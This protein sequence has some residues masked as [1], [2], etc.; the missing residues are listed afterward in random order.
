MLQNG[1]SIDGSK[2]NLRGEVFEFP[3]SIE[4]FHD[5][6]SFRKIYNINCDCI[7]DSNFL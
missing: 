2:L 6:I 1:T 3:I 5:V 4:G 7:L